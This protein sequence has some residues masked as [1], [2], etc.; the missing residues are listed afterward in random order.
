MACR[1]IK[2][3]EASFTKRVLTESH[4][5]YVSIHLVKRMFDI[6]GDYWLDKEKTQ[7]VEGCWVFIEGRESGYFVPETAANFAERVEACIREELD[8]ARVGPPPEKPTKDDST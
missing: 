1:F 7:K 6:P 3:T 2:V 4:T 8:Y 5:E